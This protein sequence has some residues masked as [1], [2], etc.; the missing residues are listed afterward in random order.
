MKFLKGKG[1]NGRLAE[2]CPK[3]N[4]QIWWDSSNYDQ[5]SSWIT[6]ECECRSWTWLWAVD[7][8]SSVSSK[9]VINERLLKTDYY[10]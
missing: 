3:C 6:G 4:T 10:S 2:F 8:Y 7:G 1:K 5:I 9:K